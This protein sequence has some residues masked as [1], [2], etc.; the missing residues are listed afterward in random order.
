MQR[1]LQLQREVFRRADE[2]YSGVD[3]LSA[4]AKADMTWEDVANAA[5]S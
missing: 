2:P 5:A 3:C 4:A 1:P